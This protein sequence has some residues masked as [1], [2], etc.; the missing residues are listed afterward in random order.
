M[1]TIKSIKPLIARYLFF[2]LLSSFERRN[3]KNLV[4][5]SLINSKK[6]IPIYL[7]HQRILQS[8]FKIFTE[9]DYKFLP[10]INKSHPKVAAPAKNV[11]PPGAPALQH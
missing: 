4:P 8:H 5:T 6:K 10:F 7:G 3:N 9:N 1:K 2:L 11:R